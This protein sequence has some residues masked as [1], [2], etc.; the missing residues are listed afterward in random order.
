MDLDGGYLA[1]V[2]DCDSA[3][4]LYQATRHDDYHPVILRIKRRRN[5]LLPISRLHRE[6]L[7]YVFQLALPNQRFRPSSHLHPFRYYVALFKLRKVSHSWNCEIVST[8]SFWT[9]TSLLFPSPFK[10]LVLG[11]SGDAAL[12]VDISKRRRDFDRESVGTDWSEVEK[13]YLARVMKRE[14]RELHMLASPAEN[15]DPY[16]I[17]RSHPKMEV[18]SLCCEGQLIS[19]RPLR[20]PQLAD[21]LLVGWSVPWD[22]ICNLQLLSLSEVTG[23]NLPQLVQILRSSPLLQ[24]L[25]LNRIVPSLPSGSDQVVVPADPIISPH[26]SAIAIHDSSFGLAS[27]LLHRL[28]P[29]NARSVS[30]DM[31]LPV[32]GEFD[33]SGFCQQAGRICLP[34]GLAGQVCEPR[35]H[36]SPDALCLQMGPDRWLNIHRL[37]WTE[38]EKQ[39]TMPGRT[40][41]ARLFL[42]AGE[43][44][45]WRALIS[46]FH[47]HVESRSAVA[48]GLAIVHDFFPEI[49]ELDV[50]ID[51]GID[52]SDVLAEP[53]IGEGNPTWL[54]PKLSVL[55]IKLRGRGGP[56]NSV[57]AMAVKRTRSASLSPTALSPIKTLRLAHGWVKS[58]SLESLSKAAINYELDSVAVL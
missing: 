52:M 41:L 22:Y 49:V 45:L 48:E 1:N 28:F 24:E 51:E 23:P 58:G 30:I 7:H 40:E 13:A 20:T 50:T 9:L 37:G 14:I 21:L 56:Y 38:R 42:G 3:I 55:D 31:R 43:G 33:M 29:S 12:D 27:G 2:V 54:L 47:L 46:R 16:L 10:D 53:I 6:L 15:L 26:L 5:S 4:T 39:S 44:M 17:D 36:I 32:E 25:K 8:P 34:A 35:L 19:I 18:L 11:R 57:I